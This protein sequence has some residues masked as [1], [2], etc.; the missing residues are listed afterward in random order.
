MI[1]KDKVNKELFNI[2]LIFPKEFLATIYLIALANN[3]PL[4]LKTDEIYQDILN[5][6]KTKK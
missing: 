4:L 3:H 2:A 5:S 6:L 1:K